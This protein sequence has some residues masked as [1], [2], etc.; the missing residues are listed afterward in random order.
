M[1]NWEVKT[2]KGKDGYC[3]G[4]RWCGYCEQCVYI[5]KAWVSN[6]A[7][8]SLESWQKRNWES[9]V[10]QGISIRNQ[11]RNAIKEIEAEMGMNDCGKD[12]KF[13][14]IKVGFKQGIWDNNDIKL[15]IEKTILLQEKDKYGL[16]DSICVFEYFSKS[17]PLGGNFHFHMLVAGHV[18]TDKVRCIKQLANWYKVKPNFVDYTIGWG[19]DKFKINLKYVMGDKCKD[20][21]KWV[22]LD[23]KWRKKK[24]LPQVVGKLCDQ[25][26][27]K[28]QELLEINETC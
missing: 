24:K 3:S 14:W 20:K 16:G 13:R 18:K 23:R 6:L 2:R 1:D 26:S 7:G 5:G 25:L 17:N 10:R 4:N 19:E 12:A 27:K 8:R 11:R 22:V 28:Y 9:E 21:M 15:V